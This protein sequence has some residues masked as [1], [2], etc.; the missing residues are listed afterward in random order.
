MRSVRHSRVI[1]LFLLQVTILGTVL[2]STGTAEASPSSTPTS[3]ARVECVAFDA[4]GTTCE[5]AG[6]VYAMTQVGGRTYIG[7]QFHTV[8]GTPRSNVAAIRTD[9]TLDPTWNPSTNGIV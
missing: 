9:G 5:I 7:G 4:S 6:V 2:A 1:R 8:S 3:T